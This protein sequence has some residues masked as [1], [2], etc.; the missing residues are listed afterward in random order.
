MNTMWDWIDKKMADEHLLFD[1]A[2]STGITNSSLLES[3][4]EVTKY[5]VMLFVRTC[6]S[7]K[8]M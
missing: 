6:M 5:H 3:D 1:S 8:W 7:Q 2:R 4:L